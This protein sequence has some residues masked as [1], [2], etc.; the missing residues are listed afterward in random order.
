MTAGFIN[1]NQAVW[2]M[3]RLC[4]DTLVTYTDGSSPVLMDTTSGA[5]GPRPSALYPRIPPPLLNPFRAR[6]GV[7]NLN[8]L[9]R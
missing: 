1:L 5:A 6:S 4:Y 3:K 2:W 8:S 7:E 9:I